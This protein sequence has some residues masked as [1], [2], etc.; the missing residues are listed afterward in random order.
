MMSPSRC[1]STHNPALQ[2]S[3][4]APP[5]FFSSDPLERK[6]RL[7]PLRQPQAILHTHAPTAPAKAAQHHALASSSLPAQLTRQPGCVRD[8]MPSSTQ[9][10]ARPAALGDHP[11]ARPSKSPARHRGAGAPSAH[12][13]V[14]QILPCV[15]DHSLGIGSLA[16]LAHTEALGQVIA[17]YFEMSR[18]SRNQRGPGVEGGIVQRPRP[19]EPHLF[20][21]LL[22]GLEL[23]A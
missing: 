13:L 21:H 18:E 22:R 5:R 11:V 6:A 17:P 23:D 10:L 15:A 9:E 19:S 1:S 14:E 7:D 3:R 8:E 4:E 12:N 2:V 20:Q 16:R